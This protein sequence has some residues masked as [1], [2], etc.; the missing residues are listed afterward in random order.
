MNIFA[1]LF[2]FQ[3]PHALILLLEEGIF[4]LLSPIPGAQSVPQL[5]ELSQCH[6]LLPSPSTVA[7]TQELHKMASGER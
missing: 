1:L 5:S 4:P 6:P 7:G 3:S 2:T